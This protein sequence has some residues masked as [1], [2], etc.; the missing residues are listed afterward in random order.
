MMKFTRRKFLGVAS[1]GVA[2]VGVASVG[3]PSVGPA[4]VNRILLVSQKVTAPPLAN[5]FPGGV[6]YI[7][8]SFIR[9]YEASVYKTFHRHP[10]RVFSVES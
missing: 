1:V 2:S 4:S 8:E 7:D 6:S 10:K 3:M 9:S 5:V